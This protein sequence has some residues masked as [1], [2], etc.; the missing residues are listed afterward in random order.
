[1]GL[2]GDKEKKKETGEELRKRLEAEAAERRRKYGYRYFTPP[3]EGNRPFAPRR[4]STKEKLE[5]WELR[6]RRHGY[7]YRSLRRYFKDQ[8]LPIFASEVGRALKNKGTLEEVRGLYHLWMS[9]GLSPIKVKH[10]PIT[11]SLFSLSGAGWKIHRGIATAGKNGTLSGLSKVLLGSEKYAGAIA[12]D[13]G[14][15]ADPAKIKP[16]QTVDVKT[17]VEIRI[18]SLWLK[19]MQRQ[20]IRELEHADWVR[21]EIGGRGNSSLHN[22][23]GVDP[24]YEHLIGNVNEALRH[25]GDLG[26]RGM[27]DTTATQ[28]KATV[29]PEVVLDLARAQS[30]GGEE[31][32][33]RMGAIEGMKRNRREALLEGMKGFDKMI[34]KWWQKRMRPVRMEISNRL[35]RLERTG[36]AR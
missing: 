3:P 31:T 23:Y 26:T 9:G 22:R 24:D 13:N 18:L 35:K 10:L 8:W 32:T 17:L 12:R 19:H 28:A 16:G 21:R 15:I 6:M 29:A 30:M 34:V 25:L 20:M 1:M 11:V 33:E 2:N 7:S 5:A 4:L 36:A 27:S 14:S